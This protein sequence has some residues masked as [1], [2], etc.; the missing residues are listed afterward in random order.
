MALNLVDLKVSA[1]YRVRGELFVDSH[2]KIDEKNFFFS[3]HNPHAERANFEK[4]DSCA[5]GGRHLAEWFSIGTGG[6]AASVGGGG[7]CLGWLLKTASRT[8]FLWANNNATA[9]DGIHQGWCGHLHLRTLVYLRPRITRGLRC[10]SRDERRFLYDLCGLLLL[11]RA[12]TER[13]FLDFFWGLFQMPESHIWT[14]GGDEPASR[15]WRFARSARRWGCPFNLKFFVIQLNAAFMLS[16]IKRIPH[17]TTHSKVR[18]FQ[19]NFLSFGNIRNR[20]S[21]NELCF[22]LNLHLIAFFKIFA[23]FSTFL[24]EAIVI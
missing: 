13:L 2:W 10:F 11:A 5:P 16:V 8:R 22:K 7:R 21:I 14:F 18:R 4:P 23:T 19:I 12:N 15:R 20:K 24:K 9:A 1:I 6:R 3:F 17:S